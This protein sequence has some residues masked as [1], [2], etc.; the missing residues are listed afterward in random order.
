[1]SQATIASA[2]PP[3]PAPS[4]RRRSLGASRS[5]FTSLSASRSSDVA[6]CRSVHHQRMLGLPPSPTP[7]GMSAVSEIAPPRHRR[8]RRWLVDVG[9]GGH[10]DVSG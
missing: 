10:L 6:A 9:G 1:M 8:P 5:A 2:L 7:V 3:L 4:V